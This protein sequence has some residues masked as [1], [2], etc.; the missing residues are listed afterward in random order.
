MTAERRQWPAP[1]IDPVEASIMV[2]VY[3]MKV[4]KGND[5][6]IEI[7]EG[8]TREVAEGRL[9][10]LADDI[11]DGVVDTH[12]AVAKTILG[13]NPFIG[14]FGGISYEIELASVRV[15]TALMEKMPTFKDN[16]KPTQQHPAK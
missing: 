11:M 7:E 13:L 4:N 8:L 9:F 3:A 15:R 14:P 6:P 16:A 12:N 10:N 5:G 1:D 2:V